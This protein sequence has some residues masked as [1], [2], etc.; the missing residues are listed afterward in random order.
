MPVVIW[1]KWKG[2]GG[3][4][5]IAAKITSIVLDGLAEVA[6]DTDIRIVDRLDRRDQRAEVAD[7]LE[8]RLHRQ[9]SRVGRHSAGLSES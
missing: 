1:K 5:P 4:V 7:A 2:G 3:R 8:R 9:D 6:A